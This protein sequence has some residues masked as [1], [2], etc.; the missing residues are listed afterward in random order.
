MRLPRALSMFKHLGTLGMQYTV[1]L[2][3]ADSTLASPVGA[4]GL[5][6]GK[7]TYTPSQPSING[8][9]GSR[10]ECLTR[11]VRL[12]THRRRESRGLGLPIEVEQKISYPDADEILRGCY[13]FTER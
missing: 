12:V 4:V 13:T 7:L 8:R 6:C 5:W 2:T 9:K 1:L 11:G 3:T 10:A